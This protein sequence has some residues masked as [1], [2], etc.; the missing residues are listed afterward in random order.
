MANGVG[1][2]FISPAT[3]LH[4]SGTTFTIISTT[5][6]PWYDWT[7]WTRS[8]TGIVITDTT[9]DTTTAYATATGTITSNYTIKTPVTPTLVSPTNGAI[10]V[11]SSVTF[12][13]SYEVADSFYVL[14]VWKTTDSAATVTWDTTTAVSFSKALDTVTA[15]SWAVQGGN[16]SGVSAYSTAWTFTTASTSITKRKRN[17]FPSI[18]ITTVNF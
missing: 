3:G 9:N 2:T 11:Y 10:N 17:T 5:S 6:K 14:R 16:A 4:D 13:W 7:K 15:Y 18:R 12:Q 1:G 8:S